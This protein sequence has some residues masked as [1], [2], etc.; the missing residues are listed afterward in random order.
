MAAPRRA[1][2]TAML[3]AAAAAVGPRFVFSDE[4]Q[5]GA[6]AIH[7]IVRLAIFSSESFSHALANRHTK[8]THTRVTQ[9]K[10]KDRERLLKI[11]LRS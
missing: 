7:H 6:A 9:K 8:H 11:F 10:I 1:E 4:Q 5:H 2:E 3:A